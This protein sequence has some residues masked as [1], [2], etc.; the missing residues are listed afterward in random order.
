MAEPPSGF[1][2]LMFNYEQ[3]ENGWILI[4]YLDL[5]QQKLI[6][7]RE[8]IIR[9]GTKIRLLDTGAILKLEGS[10]GPR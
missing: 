2:V 7:V 8:V 6:K 10:A 3:D 5:I 4:G 9:D 1:E